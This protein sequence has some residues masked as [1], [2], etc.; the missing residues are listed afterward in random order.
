MACNSAD[1]VITGSACLNCDSS[2]ATCSGTLLS[3]CKSCPANKYFLSSNNSCVACNVNGYFI[4]GSNC[5]QCDS[6]CLTCNGALATNC[7]SCPSSPTAT[8]LL[9]S[10]HSCVA[11]N[12]DRVFISGSECLPCHADCLTCNGNS[13][14]NCLTCPSSKYLLSSNF[15]CVACN[16]AGYFMSGSNC[17]PCDSN[18]LTCN[19]ASSTD[20]LSCPTSKYF[21]SSNKSCVACNVARYFISGANCL[22][23]DSSCLTCDGAS[24]NSCVT[25]PLSTYLHFS[26]HSC[27]AC[28]V[29]GFSI[30][31]TQCFECDTSCLTCNGELA[32]NCVICPT[33]KYL[34]SSN[35]SCVDCDVDGYFI[36]GSD[37]LQCDP[38]CLSC[39]GAS[40]TSCLSCPSAPATYFLDSNHSC[41]D[42]NVDRYVISGSQCLPCDS[43]C[44]TCSGT[45]ST[46]C[47]TCPSNTYLLSSN[48]SCVACDVEGHSIVGTQCVQCNPSCLTCSGTTPSNCV[49]CPSSKYLLSSNRSCVPCNVDGYFIS[50][51]E[52]FQ[53]DPT[54][55]T[56]NGS[57]ANN[58]LSCTSDKSL[59]NFTC[60]A[61]T[62]QEQ[63]V[64]ISSAASAGE[65]TGAAMQATTAASSILPVVTGG[66]STSAILL[67]GFLADIDL[68]KYINVP[69]P[70][71]FVSFC[72]QMDANALPNLFVSMDD[73]YEGNNPNSTIG[74]Y[75]FWGTSATL[76]DNSSVTIFKDLVILGIIIGLNILI[77]ILRGF[78]SLHQKLMKIRGLFM[79]NLF[80]SYYLGD[81][82][83]LQLN[84]MIQL[85]E[86]NLAGTYQG[87]SFA[88]ALLIVISYPLML[89]YLIYKVNRRLPQPLN[90]QE[91]EV[92]KWAEVPASIEILVE[93]F[94]DKNSTTR[95]FLF[96]MLL[97]SS[98]Q[99]LVVFFLQDSGLAQAILYTIIGLVYIALTASQIPYKSKFQMALLL[100]NQISKAVMGIIAILFGL[101]D[102]IQFLSS[103]LNDLIGFVLML[104]ILIVIGINF[105]ISMIIMF[106]ALYRSIN[107]WRASSK[108]KCDNTQ[109]RAGA[110]I[111]INH[112]KKNPTAYQSQPKNEEDSMDDLNGREHQSFR[113]ESKRRSYKNK[114]PNDYLSKQGKLTL[115]FETKTSTESPS[116]PRKVRSSAST[117]GSLQGRNA[118]SQIEDSS[119]SS[120]NSFDSAKIQLRNRS[121]RA[122]NKFSLK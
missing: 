8:Y 50:G 51:S 57:L 16:V 39:N 73:K 24:A 72:E 70:D 21:L 107:A 11:C 83:E 80:L 78:Q 104:L 15:S 113:Q 40:A 59:Q 12:V 14:T 106:H 100:L 22:P 53:C 6:S 65:L 108:K 3:E 81:F 48:H 25:C 20:C 91:G 58:C 75:H 115:T 101:N 46:S 7:L 1:Q 35:S 33:S 82:S 84:S 112:K 76:L 63:P 86:N 95:N 68:Y 89:G 49:T 23:C 102:K 110:H 34:L 105:L 56:C 45:T 17:L 42:C 122:A 120:L 62:R 5:T 96:F 19:G 13:A 54:C 44:L 66:V 9:S 98:L 71:N 32:T 92:Q 114:L 31:G 2:C 93:D 69:F 79:W 116:L 28:N 38:S 61:P 47:V 37:C 64:L 30:V 10:N 85:R 118:K 52:C 111:K 88:F 117:K 26:E 74:K 103:S 55:L 18:C 77:L 29:D 119:V 67:V 97:E 94:H 90:T 36:S 87:L 109:R 27:I 60:V 41:V 4:S 121:S 99:I 43:S